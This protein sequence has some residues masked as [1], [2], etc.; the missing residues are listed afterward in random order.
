[1][2]YDHRFINADVSGRDESIRMMPED[3]TGTR[4]FL[5]DPPYHAKDCK[6][7]EC[8]PIDRRACMRELARVA[9]P[10][11]WLVWLDCYEPLHRK[12]EWDWV[13]FFA[14]RVCN[15]HQLRGVWIYQRT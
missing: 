4:L 12:I 3:F 15:S 9:E 6:I 11:A 13:G 14:L 10:G 1:M 8:K 7:Y 2:F 5:A